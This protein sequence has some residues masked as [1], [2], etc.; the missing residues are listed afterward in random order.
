MYTLYH[1]PGSCSLAVK[2]ALTLIGTDYSTRRLDL[3]KGEH[4][5]EAYKRINP[6]NRVPA[7]AMNQQEDA[8]VLT[9]GSAILL[10]LASR[11]PEAELMP[12]PGTLAYANALKW[13]Q[14]LN[15]TIHPHWG[16]VF[17]PERYGNEVASIRSAAE[18]ELHK[19]YSLIEVQLAK[20]PY[21]AGQQLTLADLYLMV[22]VHWEQAL[23]TPFSD[24]Y[25]RL[26]A[27]RKRMYENPVIG[28][29]YRAEFSA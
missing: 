9:E 1:I 24:G 16:R 21:I 12:E 18:A 8:D 19:L 13:L 14:L 17:A 3:A 22:T 4:L 5:T 28:E 2:A 6:L 27:Y 20:Q 29:L 15:A 11:F 7:L 26:A 25:P 10:Y 23:Q